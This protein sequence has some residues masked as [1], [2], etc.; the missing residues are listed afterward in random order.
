[1]SFCSDKTQKSP[2]KKSENDSSRTNNGLEKMFNNLSQEYRHAM[3]LNYMQ[4]PKTN[5]FDINEK[6]KAMLTCYYDCNDNICSFEEC[7][8]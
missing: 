6:E 4:F 8:K 5:T 3:L 1:M 7:K 2:E